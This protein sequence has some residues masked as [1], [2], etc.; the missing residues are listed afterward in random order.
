MLG[1]VKAVPTSPALLALALT[2]AL[3]GVLLAITFGTESEVPTT[4]ASADE[5]GAVARDVP[6]LPTTE[7]R[8]PTAERLLEGVADAIAGDARRPAVQRETGRAGAAAIRGR[9]IGPDGSSGVA[10]LRLK[11]R[12]LSRL[13]DER[14]SA[15]DGSFAF[16]GLA[17]GLHVIELDERDVPPG[18]VAMTDASG[19]VARVRLEDGVDTEVLVRLAVPARVEVRVTDEDG[20]PLAFSDVRLVPDAG[21]HRTVHRLTDEQGVAVF[22]SLRPGPHRVHLAARGG[23]SPAPEPLDLA[24]GDTRYVE[25]SYAD[26]TGTIVT[27]R[28]V[29]PNGEPLPRVDVV[30][31]GPGGATSGDR[32]EARTD[33]HGRF[34]VG[35]LPAATYRLRVE[36]PSRRPSPR[37]V[38]SPH[39]IA[40]SNLGG[41]WDVGDVHVHWGRTWILEVDYAID[42]SWAEREGIDVE[43]QSVDFALRGSQAAPDADDA[44]GAHDPVL[45]SE[46]DSRWITSANERLLIWGT[47]WPRGDESGVWDCDLVVTLVS[48]TRHL[49]ETA[50]REFRFPLSVRRGHSHDVV[51]RIP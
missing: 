27:G 49:E 24:S 1:S 40:V 3:L 7:N 34:S 16:D 51:V 41:E 4:I 15:D 46:I 18:L 45:E 37:T 26:T 35:R 12:R 31:T 19:H 22:E 42:A 36:D 32:Y 14:V 23:A 48:Y 33:E 10:G 39:E 29:G 8:V 43:M 2:V 21:V 13:V 44:E 47:D 9:C 20:R 11:L 17:R 50:P 5:R 28:I 30:L 6:S 25:M 38:D